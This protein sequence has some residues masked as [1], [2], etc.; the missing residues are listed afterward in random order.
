MT[1]H[2][3]PWLG[4]HEGYYG[5]PLEDDARL[6]LIA[7]LG[8]NG[9]DT[10]GYAPKDDPKHRQ[11]WREPYTAD[12]LAYFRHLNDACR[13]VGM[14][15]GVSMSP[16]LDWRFDDPGEIDALTAK[17]EAFHEIGIDVLGVQWDDVPGEGP[18]VGAAHGRATAQVAARLGDGVRFSAAPVD[19]ATAAPTPYLVAFAAELPD[20]MGIG[21]T[22][23]S[24]LTKRMTAEEY[25]A[26]E[27]AV[28]CPVGWAE[29]FP[30]NDL[31]MADVMHLGPY[32]WRDP[33]LREIVPSV[34]VNFM[35]RPLASRLGLGLAAAF[36]RQGETDRDKAWLTA[37]QAVDGLEPIA[38][39]CRSWVDDPGPDA[40]LLEWADGALGG[41]RRL[42]SYLEAGCRTGLDAALEAELEPWL[43]RW[44]EE[45]AVML[46][47]LDLL[48]GARPAAI[49]P[50]WQAAGLWTR[51]RN[52]HGPQVFGI[53]A[54]RY[55]MTQHVNGAMVAAPGAVVHGDNLTDR[56]YTKAVE[57]LEALV[58][59]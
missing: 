36:W 25:L 59:S 57:H 33:K 31:G 3:G 29:N 20:G 52:P 14:S 4:A 28:G 17:L 34:S 5:P 53:R 37:V 30:V 38:R 42:R 13:D 58:T 12:E 27:Q 16:G 6:A 49:L 2:R 22:G 9:Y 47:V 55:P 56:L 45:A 32:P 11:L 21:W 1:E 10:Y 18:V 54:A 24:V 43:A 19:Y 26:F 44:E 46:A 51:V 41:D 39:A 35:S 8:Q 23:P 48:D 15:L 7:W 40:T 50:L